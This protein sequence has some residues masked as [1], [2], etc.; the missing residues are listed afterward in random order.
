MIEATPGRRPFFASAALALAA[1]AA[2]ADPVMEK[3]QPG[4]KGMSGSSVHVYNKSKDS[5]TV[6]GVH[7]YGANDRNSST[8]IDQAKYEV[9]LNW[10]NKN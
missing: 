6:Y 9:L 10:K 4:N 7:A 1:F 8:R 5:H 2:S 3:S